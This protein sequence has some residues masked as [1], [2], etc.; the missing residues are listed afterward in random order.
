VPALIPAGLSLFH[1]PGQVNI[2]LLTILKTA[3]FSYLLLACVLVLIAIAG[4]R[5]FRVSP[6]ASSPGTTAELTRLAEELAAIEARE[7]Q[8]AGT[9]WAKELLAQ[10]SGLRFDRFWDALNHAADKWPVVA[11]FEFENLRPGVRFPPEQ[12]AHG[13]ELRQPD[14][15]D[16]AN[17]G[18]VWD[19][20]EWLV[21]IEQA[22]EAGWQIGAVEFRHNQFEVDGQRYPSRSVFTFIAQL[23]NPELSRRATL[24]GDLTVVWG[25]AQFDQD[26]ELPTVRSVDASGVSL[27]ERAGPVPF[28]P[29]LTRTVTPPR[30]S[31]FIDPLIL[32]DLDGD[33]LSEIIL[34]SSNLVFR[35][36]PD[37][38]YQEG[39]LLRHSPGLLFTAV[40]ADFDGDGHA[41]FLCATFDGLLLYRGSAAGTFEAPGEMVWSANPRL[42]YGQVLT[43]GD[44]NGNG[45][46]D[47]WLGQYRPP[48]ERGQMPTPYH[49]ANDGHPDWLLIN[50]GQG[51]FTDA[52]ESAG[53]SAKR[54]RRSYSGSFVDLDG[55]GNLDLLVV[56][57]FAGIDLYANDGHGRFQDATRRWITERRAF[58]MGH[59][60]ADFNRDGF[61]DFLV[62]GMHCPAAQRLE[63]LNLTRPGLEDHDGIRAA[64]IEGNRL[65]LGRSDGGFEQTGLNESIARTGWSWGCA[66]LDFD[67]DGWPDVYIVN[68]HETRQSVRD[69]EP[70][71][72]LHDIYV[73]DSEEDVVRAA[74]FGAKFARTRGRGQSYGGYEKNR[75]YLN[76]EGQAFLEI[77]HLMGVGV[78]VDARNVAADDLDGDGRADLIF[79][80]FE[81]WPEERQTLQVYRNNLATAGNWIGVRLREEGHGKSPI[82]A[83]VSLHH[84]GG[85]TLRPIITGDSHRTQ[86]APT[87]HFGLG[88]LES[89]DRLEI[90]WLDGRTRVLSEPAINRYHLVSAPSP[91][92]NHSHGGE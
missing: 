69:Y 29:V 43:C 62:L 44:I 87:V 15:S 17:V 48:Y 45:H 70:E 6:P 92:E 65:Y 90:R 13:M 35:R 40:I 27:V 83:R 68:G 38:Q 42:R 50:D 51:R 26:Q 20:A 91:G 71:F 54:W 73:A 5:L 76:R 7:Q 25:P 47:V 37:G 66:V 64:M 61:L 85:S 14:R 21:W 16:P 78:E 12:L 53:L 4:W 75:L 18:P 84:A 3:R 11:S 72:W 28:Q 49:D 36:R 46:L 82:G 8:I 10:Q 56:S 57:D 59:A 24:E 39:P 33:G 79:T 1:I 30:G 22:R 52:T 80:T 88:Q 34:A 86:H 55:N 41:D 23:V 74:Y 67:N 31:F 2:R 77:G 60:L 81:T 32:Y 58:G 89:V 63:H 9:I 19:R